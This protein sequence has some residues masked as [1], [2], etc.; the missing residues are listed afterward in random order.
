MANNRIFYAVV[1]VGI[2]PLGHT[3]FFSV[4]GLQTLGINTRFNLQQVFE[5]GQIDLYEN[6]EDIPEAE[7]TLEKVLDGTCPVYMYATSG[8]A[9]ATLVGRSAKRATLAVTFHTDTQSSASGTPLAQ[10]TMSGVYCSALG[11]NFVVDG[12]FTES[13]TLVCNDKSWLTSSFTFTPNFTNLDSPLAAEGVNRRQHLLMG[14]CRF[15]TE[16][17]GISS[18]G[19]NNLASNEYGVHFQSIRHSV[20]LGRNNLLE[21]GRKAPYFRYIQFPTEVRTDYE[22]NNI[23]GDR[24]NAREESSN[25]TNQT[26]ITDT[27]EGLRINCGTKNKLASVTYGG[28]NATNQGGNATT[29]YSYTNFNIMTVTHPQDCT[30]AI[31]A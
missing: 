12:P 14:D 26:I 30:A 29:T 7:A 1:G 11:Y 8:A 6:Y 24:V 9:D 5:I 20:N 18:S 28:A 3:A 21:L 23:T 15:P 19:T 27:T 13:V 2:A 17:P 22:I 4:K 31:A 16:I 25:L 10:M